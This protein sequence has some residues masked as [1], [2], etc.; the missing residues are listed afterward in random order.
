[1]AG[2]QIAEVVS[3]MSELMTF[4]IETSQGPLACLHTFA[5]SMLEEKERLRAARAAAGMEGPVSA[6][7]VPGTPDVSTPQLLAH[8][9][10]PSTPQE[11]A[12]TES[13]EPASTSGGSTPA[14]GAQSTAGKKRAA[15]GGSATTRRAR[16]SSTGASTPD[17]ARS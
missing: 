11:A 4:S 16:T 5:A 9:Q 10:G 3:H 13:P 15:K 17:P 12:N 2:R 7:S 14:G 1:M 8:Q 6:T